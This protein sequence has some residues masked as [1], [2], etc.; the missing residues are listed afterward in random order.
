MLLHWEDRNS[1]AHGVESRVPYLDHRLVEF[2]VG[3]PGEAK[4]HRGVLKK[5]LR[6][7]CQGLIPDEIRLRT[8]KIGFVAPEVDWLRGPLRQ[9]FETAFAYAIERSNGIVSRGLLGPFH[10]WQS[11]AK[12]YMAAF[13]RVAMFGQW[14]DVFKVD[15]A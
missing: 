14:L 4:V 12:P 15:T 8:D 3:L 13:W 9:H 11:G 6:E 10:S 5:I 2:T 7:S 1:M